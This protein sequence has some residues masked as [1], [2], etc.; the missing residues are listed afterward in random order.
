VKITQADGAGYLVSGWHDA[1]S[2]GVWSAAARAMIGFEVPADVRDPALEVTGGPL[3]L[4][5][6]VVLRVDDQP[7]VRHTFTRRDETVS[8]A[9][10]EGGEHDVILTIEVT[11]A[12][13]PKS[14]GF[15]DD[16]RSL[17]FALA[18]LRLVNG[19]PE[20]VEAAA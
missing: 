20:P 10:G 16:T 4:P 13:S 12:A 18:G 19:S 5:G 1:E 9:L 14:L 7:V 8:V 2:W 17:G 11:E 15:S 6:E 3:H